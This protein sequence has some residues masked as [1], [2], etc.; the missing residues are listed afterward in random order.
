MD[1]FLEL[2]IEAATSAGKLLREGI[3]KVSWVRHKGEINLVTEM[4]IRS[5]QLIKRKIRSAH[6]DHQIL[7]E[8]SDI[9]AKGAGFRWVIDPLDG[10]TNYAHGFPIFCVSVA[11]EIEGVVELGAVYDPMRDELFTGKRGTGAMMN[12][13]QIAVSHTTDLNDSLLAT[14]FPY[15]LRTSEANNVDHWNAM[16]VRAQAVRRAGSAALDLCYTAMGRFDGF[17]ELKL[18][19][20]DVAAGALFVQE[21]GGKVTHLE[22]ETFS[23]YS[24]EVLAS[25]G[26]I[27]SQ[28]VE[29]LSKGNRP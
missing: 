6:P 18:Y 7:A 11:L 9:P 22:G 5:E 8:E 24:K 29:I 4:D 21:A 2:A 19:P 1:K 25:N 28:M 27:H 26:K 14:G 16:L 13:K 17:W 10:T 15:D 23:I 20:W 3:D 12:G